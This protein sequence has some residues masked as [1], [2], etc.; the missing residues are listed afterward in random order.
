MHTRDFSVNIDMFI[1]PRDKSRMSA[2]RC[3]KYKFQIITKTQ[4]KVQRICGRTD[5][6][7][8]PQLLWLELRLTGIT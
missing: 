5:H 8:L 4:F 6:R 2:S 3:L 1:V 7:E